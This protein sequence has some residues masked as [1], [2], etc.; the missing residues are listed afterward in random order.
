MKGTIMATAIALTL[1][2]CG[3]NDSETGTSTSGDTPTTGQSDS[4]GMMSADTSATTTATGSAVTGDTSKPSLDSAK[5][6]GK[7]KS[8]HKDTSS[9]KQ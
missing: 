9:H 2:S 8:S 3:S 7:K 1:A 5:L 6:K 4:V